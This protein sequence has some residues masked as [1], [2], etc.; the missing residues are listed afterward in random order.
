MSRGIDAI[1]T[2]LP[3]GSSE[4]TIIVSV[5]QRVA[6]RCR[7]PSPISSTLMRGT[8][9]VAERMRSGRATGRPRASGRVRRVDREVRVVRVRPAAT[10]PVGDPGAAFVDRLEDLVAASRASTVSPATTSC[11]PTMIA[12][13]SASAA[14]VA[15]AG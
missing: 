3:T 4:T 13:D 2:V 11:G 7:S 6:G 12:S 5:R 15:A 8:A 9:G 14:M 10:V 1:E